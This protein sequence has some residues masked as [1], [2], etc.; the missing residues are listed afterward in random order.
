[1]RRLLLKILASIST[2]GV[3]IKTML[4]TFAMASTRF[5]GKDSGWPEAIAQDS[6]AAI[7]ACL[8]QG[9]NVN[10]Q[11]ASGVTPLM[12]AVDRIKLQAAKALLAAGAQVNAKA[13]DN[14]TAIHLAV[15]GYKQQPRAM[16]D[17]LFAAG[18][19]PNTRRPNDDP[20]IVRALNDRNAEFVRYLVG[21]GAS[22][23][24]DSR[25]EDRLLYYVA[26]GADWDMV[27]LMLELGARYDDPGLQKKMIIRLKHVVPSDDSPIYP[28][29]KWVWELFKSKGIPVEELGSR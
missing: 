3:I 15:Q 1:M 6:E 9:A 20:I 12:I 25:T 17:L 10:A 23:D 18:A 19:N 21:K 5:S 11:D 4:G 24:V 27:A 13:K 8:A 29:K 16:L 7:K 22:L 14:T 26:L 2:V 28:Y